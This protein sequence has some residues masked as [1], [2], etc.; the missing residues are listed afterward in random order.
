MF[1]FFLFERCLEL[2]LAELEIQCRQSLPS[3]S[4]HLYQH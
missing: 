2:G 3:H 4:K 1:D